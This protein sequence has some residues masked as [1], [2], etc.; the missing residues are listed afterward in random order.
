MGRRA[1]VP[2][3]F[4]RGDIYW[5]RFTV[6]GKRY[7]LSTDCR[8][9]RE[10]EAKA[11]KLHA[12]AQLG[13]KL[14]RHRRIRSDVTTPLEHLVA[15][16]LIWAGANKSASYVKAQTKHFR[17]HFLKA[18]EH[19]KPTRW[20]RL[21][22]ITTETIE[23]YKIDRL[24][25]LRA[26][27]EE[28]TDATGTV[29]VYKE[30]VT[31]SRFMRWCHKIKG[32]IS[33]VPHFDRIK[34]VS[35]YVPLDLSPEQADRL[36]RE[37]P[38]RK[39][40]P[41]R[42]PVRERFEVQWAQA[43][44]PGEVEAIR[45]MDVNLDGSL[46]FLRQS[47]DKGRVRGGRWIPMHKRAHRV[48][49][50]LAKEPHKPEALVFGVHRYSESLKLAAARAGLPNVTPHHFRHARLTELASNTKDTAAVQYLAGHKSLATTDRYV[51]S[52]VERVRVVFE[53]TDAPRRKGRRS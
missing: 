28:P 49:S 30:L 8:D 46:I 11:A 10:A 16:Y 13:R 42:M 7:R 41:K 47:E 48:L 24:R 4:L 15:E 44:R 25:E 34:P 40:H 50:E 52:R 23:Q 43:M 29:T 36:L 18:D 19:G 14:S 32:L 1:G 22:D 12:E 35:D 6:D 17:A 3:L 21:S 51:R 39:T 20:K 53:A 2:V 38:D 5:C 45:W 27:N 33:E 9:A 26:A 31:L 37:L